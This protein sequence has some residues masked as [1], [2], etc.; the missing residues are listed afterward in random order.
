[1]VNCFLLISSPLMGILWV[2]CYINITFSSHDDPTNLMQ[3]MTH[4]PGRSQA[5]YASRPHSDTRT[6]TLQISSKNKNHSPPKKVVLTNKWVYV[7][8]TQKTPQMLP[9]CCFNSV[10]LV[11]NF[12]QFLMPVGGGWL[13]L[14]MRSIKRYEVFVFPRSCH[15]SLR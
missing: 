6:I 1:M 11:G 9:S 5:N 15:Y 10:L 3:N 2:N 7:A 13:F 12:Y 4:A 14:L 8:Y